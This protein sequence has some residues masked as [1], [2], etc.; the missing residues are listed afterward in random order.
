MPEKTEKA[1]V[2]RDT[3]AHLLS[4]KTE[5]NLFEET[6]LPTFLNGESLTAMWV[7]HGGRRKALVYLSQYA[8]R[9][10]FKKLGKYLI[11]Y[12]DK[13]ELVD[14]TPSAYFQLILRKLL[15]NGKK[16]SGDEEESF[17]LLKDTVRKFIN[18]KYH[19]I[20][21]LGNFDELPF[22]TSFYNNLNN[23]WELD[24]K[25]VHFIFAVYKDIFQSEISDKYGRL[26]EVIGQNLVYL[27]LLNSEDS[28]IAGQ[29][30]KTKY[31]YILGKNGEEL[32]YD[33]AGG[34]VA[35]LKA[36]MRLASR[37]GHV[38]SKEE[39]IE[40][41]AKQWEVETILEDIWQ[42]LNESE[43]NLL[44]NIQAPKSIRSIPDRLVKLRLLQP[45]VNGGFTLFSRLFENFVR[46]RAGQPQNLTIDREN[47]QLLLA[48]LPIKEKITLQEYH[49]LS[50]FLEKPNV[51]LSRDDIGQALWGEK[52]YDKY[53]DWAID[54]II[55]QL[56]KKLEKIGTLPASLQTIR[57]R[58]YR[59]I[60]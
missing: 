38:M 20:F 52:S 13:D 2:K 41:L 10:G 14:E 9:F 16:V 35:L 28:Q 4:E 12:V 29:Y 60:T 44:T 59:W 34:N 17:L 39:L 46:N 37:I 25:L 36:T 3:I 42:A 24:K 57:G 53:S 21:L 23:L 15:G 1:E 6:I 5:K 32:I 30:L 55:S 19:L 47:G 45:K 18:Q 50:T 31:G 26:R 48:G 8:Q 51:V 49:L 7:P 40:L 56:R 33:L 43:K 58:G 27:P 22:T 11:L 54:Q